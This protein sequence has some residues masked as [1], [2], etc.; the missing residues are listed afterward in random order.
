MRFKQKCTT[1]K[2]MFT[3]M[4]LNLILSLPNVVTIKISEQQKIMLIN[5]YYAYCYVCS[6]LCL[7]SNFLSVYCIVMLVTIKKGEKMKI[8]LYFE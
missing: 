5:Q 3:Q 7:L 2:L 6:N 8:K 4:R 1:I